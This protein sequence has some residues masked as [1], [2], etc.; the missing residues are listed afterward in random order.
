MNIFELPADER[1]Y[2]VND[3]YP[4]DDD[5]PF[6]EGPPARLLWPPYQQSVPEL[7]DGK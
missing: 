1:P 4:Y 2:Y 7:G 6:Y 3:E 5:D